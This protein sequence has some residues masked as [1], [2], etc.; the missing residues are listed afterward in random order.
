MCLGAMA[1]GDAARWLPSCMHIFHRGCV[2]VWLREHLTCPVCG[3]EVDIRTTCEGCDEM[4]QEV[5]PSRASSSMA[6]PTRE[7]LLDD[8]ERDLESVC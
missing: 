1:E 8:G 4:D 6:Q 2:D 3:A 5:G 7:G